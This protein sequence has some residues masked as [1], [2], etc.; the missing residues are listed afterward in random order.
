MTLTIEQNTDQDRNR[1]RDQ[2]NGGQYV[3]SP[4]LVQV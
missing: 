1:D 2:N 4:V 3:M